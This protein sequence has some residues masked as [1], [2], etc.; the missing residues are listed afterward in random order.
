MERFIINLE[1]KMKEA[2]FKL[3]NIVFLMKNK[4]ICKIK[5]NRFSLSLFKAIKYAYQYQSV[6]R[7]TNYNKYIF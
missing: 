5:Y 7:S 3:F 1:P 2:I 6:D 4:F